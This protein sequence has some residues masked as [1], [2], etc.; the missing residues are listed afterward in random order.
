MNMSKIKIFTPVVVAV[1]QSETAGENPYCTIRAG[2][3]YETNRE[4]CNWAAC[5]EDSFKSG[6]GF[7]GNIAAVN[8]TISEEIIDLEGW[9]RFTPTFEVEVIRKVEYRRTIE[10]CEEEVTDTYEAELYAE[11]NMVEDIIWDTDMDFFDEETEI[12]DVEE[13]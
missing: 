12:G 11:S 6:D 4:A 1:R 3:P 13:Q 2:T 7:S 9:E 10:V 5:I 8:T